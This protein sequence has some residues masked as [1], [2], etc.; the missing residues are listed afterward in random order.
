M[1]YGP[2]RA[3]LPA[4][5][6]VENS[7]FSA[8]NIPIFTAFEIK[9]G[10]LENFSDSLLSRRSTPSTIC[11]VLKK[12]SGGV[13]GGHWRGKGEREQREVKQAKGEEDGAGALDCIR[14]QNAAA[15]SDNGGQAHHR[16]GGDSTLKILTCVCF[17]GA[18]AVCIEKQKNPG[19]KNCVLP[20]PALS[21]W[22]KEDRLPYFSALGPCTSWWST[23]KHVPLTH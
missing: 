12:S 16:G 8:M 9:T 5:F 15:V 10:G 3:F 14:G 20:T 7:H 23:P 4:I 22:A 13:W 1:N 17:C 11:R 21:L 2:G 19:K 18:G 6:C